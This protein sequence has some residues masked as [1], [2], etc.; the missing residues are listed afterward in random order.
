MTGLVASSAT[1][2]FQMCI[3]KER[4]LEIQA[5]DSSRYD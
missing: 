4:K 3:V 5:S 1:I 2:K